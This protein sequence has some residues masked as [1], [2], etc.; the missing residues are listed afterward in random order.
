MPL[1]RQKAALA[2]FPTLV[3]LGRAVLRI[4]RTHAKGGSNSM[5]EVLLLL[6]AD[7][8]VLAVS[9][10]PSVDAAVAAGSVMV[11]CYCYNCFNGIDVVLCTVASA[12]K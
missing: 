5:A 3:E 4:R 2:S 12:N 7:C 11:D 8:G 9:G 6:W 1:A 10:D